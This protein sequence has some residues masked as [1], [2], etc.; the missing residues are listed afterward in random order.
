M[1]VSGKV[2]AGF[3][4]VALLASIYMTSKAFGVRDAWMKLAQDNEKAIK[5][6]KETIEQKEK[7]LR[8]KRGDYARTMLGW[9]RESPCTVAQVDEKG[10][11]GLQLGTSGGATPGQL[12]YVFAS[13]PDNTSVYVGD[14]LIEQANETASRAKTNSRRRASDLKPAQYQN[15]RVRTMIPISLKKRLGDLDQQLLAAELELRSNREELARQGRLTQQTEKLI[16]ARMFELNGNPDMAEKNVPEVH[17]RGLLSAIVVEEENRNAAL[18]DAD[19]LA[20]KLKRTRDELNALRQ[21]NVERVQ[22]LSLPGESAPG[23]ESASR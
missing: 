13:N 22:A 3:L 14:F 11:I 21:Q 10:N 8:E 5:T 19:R 16:T 9:D 20:R 23:N 7:E 1:H 12:I 18:L 4:V 15:L 17:L 2:F 6:N